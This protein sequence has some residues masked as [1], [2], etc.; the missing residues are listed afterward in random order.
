MLVPIYHT[1][2]HYILEDH[3]LND[4]YYFISFHIYTTSMALN[5]IVLSDHMQQ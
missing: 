1:T 2:W 4:N 5:I 3:D